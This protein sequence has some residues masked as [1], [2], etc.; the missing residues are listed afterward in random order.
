MQHVKQYEITLD[1]GERKIINDTDLEKGHL[2]Y[3]ELGLGFGMACVTGIQHLPN[4]R[5][6]DEGG[7]R[8][9]K[10]NECE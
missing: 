10:P 1:T 8:A 7:I 9:P 6:L 4:E 3:T 5:I 2:Y